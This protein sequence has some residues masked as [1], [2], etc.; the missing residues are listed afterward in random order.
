MIRIVSIALLLA[1]VAG[2]SF[3]GRSPAPSYYVLTARASAAVW[4]A[5]TWR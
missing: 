2:C 5:R 4:S 3:G 1:L